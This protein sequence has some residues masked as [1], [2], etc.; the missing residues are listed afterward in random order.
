LNRSL[1]R[2]RALAERTDAEPGDLDALPEA[3]AHADLMVSATG[4]AGL[5]LRADAVRDAMRD[6]ERPLFILDLAVPRDVEASASELPRVTLVDME[7]LRDTLAERAAGTADDLDR[8][9]ELVVDEVHRFTVRRRSDRL[10][11]L[12]HALRERGDAVAAAELERFRAELVDLTP[13]ERD[14]VAALARGIVAKLLH[15]PIVRLKEL[16]APGT[17]DAY[18]RLLAR[19]FDVDPPGDE[20]A[21]PRTLD[22]P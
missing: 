3:L 14:A 5:V 19:L 10:A 17:E 16:N 15:E 21:D 4:A 2:A 22:A 6:G 11:P 20:P 9:Q 18:A 12:I 8:A 7:G 13:D 1:E